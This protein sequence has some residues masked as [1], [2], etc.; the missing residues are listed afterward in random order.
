MEAMQSTIY[1]LQQELK[2]TKEQLQLARLEQDRTRSSPAAPAGSG[3]TDAGG[4]VSAP[5]TNCAASTL[6][7]AATLDR[8]TDPRNSGGCGG[9]ET[10]RTTSPAASLR[11]GKN[12]IDSDRTSPATAASADWTA[13]DTGVVATAGN[14]VLHAR[15]P[16]ESSGG[17]VAMETDG[18]DVFKSCAEK[19]QQQQPTR[20]SPS[21]GRE[22]MAE[23]SDDTWSSADNDDVDHRA[24]RKRRRKSS[25][26]MIRA[27]SEEQ[28]MLRVTVNTDVAGP[29]EPYRTVKATSAVAD[30]SLNGVVSSGH[31]DSF[32]EEEEN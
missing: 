22:A 15:P 2:E 18:V 12:R 3:G 16:Q 24:G 10:N 8:R 23:D 7:A 6:S 31:Y 28:G 20:R 5:V 21:D 14:G 29:L 9:V 32:G 30:S 1:L 13:R 27:A 26:T 11:T 4:V 19:K 17:D 25:L